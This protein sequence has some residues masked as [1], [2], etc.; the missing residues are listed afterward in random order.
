MPGIRR[1]RTNAPSAGL[2]TPFRPP[3]TF[4]SLSSPVKD[5]AQRGIAAEK[6]SARFRDGVLTVRLPKAE[7][8]KAHPRSIPITSA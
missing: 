3:P 8:R 4:P 6:I 2:L 7:E 1:N 5:L